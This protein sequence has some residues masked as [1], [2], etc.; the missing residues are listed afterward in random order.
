[1]IQ[2]YKEILALQVAQCMVIGS[3]ST[4]ADK[5]V[6]KI[7][8]PGGIITYISGIGIYYPDGTKTQGIG[9]IPDVYIRPTREGVKEGRDELLEK[10]IELVRN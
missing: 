4:G 3:P 10:A 9:I 8:L 5:N 1:M 6:V 2:Y 7:Q